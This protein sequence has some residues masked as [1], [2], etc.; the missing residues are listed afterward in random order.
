MLFHLL[1]LPMFIIIDLFRIKR[2]IHTSGNKSSSFGSSSS[3]ESCSGSGSSF[4]PNWSWSFSI[5]TLLS[6]TAFTSLSSLETDWYF[7]RGTGDHRWKFNGG[8]VTKEMLIS[9]DSLFWVPSKSGNFVLWLSLSWPQSCNQSKLSFSPLLTPL[10]LFTCSTEC[11]L[12]S[13]RRELTEPFYLDCAWDASTF[14]ISLIVVA[15]SLSRAWTF[16]NS[17]IISFSLGL[18]AALALAW[19]FSVLEWDTNEPFFNDN[20]SF[21][22]FSKLSLS[23]LSHFLLLENQCLFCLEKDSGVLLASHTKDP[24]I[25]EHFSPLIST[26]EWILW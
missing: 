24:P 23:S 9:W 21:S 16:L 26:R 19:F 13:L 10:L 7:N 8:L 20:M 15:L 1:V 17:V 14:F 3:S 2:I 5:I 11:F 22:M 6:G 18:G 25:E 12:S 4:T